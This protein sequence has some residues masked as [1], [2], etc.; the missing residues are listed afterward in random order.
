M[1]NQGI[2]KDENGEDFEIVY[3]RE[4]DEIICYKFKKN[5]KLNRNFIVIFIV[6]LISCNSY[7]NKLIKGSD[8]NNARENIVTDFIHTYNTPKKY[9]K[10]RNGKPFDVFWIFERETNNSVLLFKVSPVKDGYISQRVEDKLGKVPESYFPNNFIVKENMLFVWKDTIT[11][12]SKNVLNILNEFNLLDSTDIKKEL[13]TLPENFQDTRMVS[14][15]DELKGVNYF[16]CPN[17][18]LKYKK[19]VTNK[20]FGYYKLPNLNCD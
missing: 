15:D 16:V 7:K 9:L 17:N 1:Q 6:L 4:N 19:V 10:K 13:N 12:L 5:Q 18:I 8:L 2:Q 11:P 14:F 20:A 3:C